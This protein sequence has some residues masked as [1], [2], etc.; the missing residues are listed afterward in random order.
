V[1]H[2]A[3][4]NDHNLPHDA[5]R[6]RLRGKR[7]I[8]SGAPRTDMYR[9]VLYLQAWRGVIGEDL[10]ESRLAVDSPSST[11]CYLPTTALEPGV[12]EMEALRG[13]ELSLQ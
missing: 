6:L 11:F 12:R 13:S 5:R 3:V 9:T 7:T 10:E 8:E 4:T 2:F 1:L